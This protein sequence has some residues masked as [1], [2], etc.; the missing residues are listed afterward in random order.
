MSP[1][2]LGLLRALGVILL[3]SIVHFFTNAANLDGVVGQSIA[4]IV[5]MIALAIE[6]SMESRSGNAL[7]GLVRSQ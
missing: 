1:A 6:H 4:P 3:A 5:A 7:F 2:L